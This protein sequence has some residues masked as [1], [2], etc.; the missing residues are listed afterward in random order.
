MMKRLFGA[1]LFSLLLATSYSQSLSK[2]EQQ[3]I[4]NID[5][6]MPA[7][8]ALLKESV[9]INSGTFNTAGIKK[10]GE[11]YAK[12][13]QALGFTIEWITMPD[14]LRRAGHL[15]AYRKGKKGKKLF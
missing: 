14:S 6:G 13:L 15:V 3:I 8:W 9:N 12:E 7:T 10:T 1:F 5:A 11:L 2:A 4:K